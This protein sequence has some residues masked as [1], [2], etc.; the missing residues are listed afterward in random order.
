M[1]VM[2]VLVG[3]RPQLSAQSVTS[4]DI[5][6]AV[7]DPSGAVLPNIE[8]TLKNETKG[9][10]S[11]IYK[12]SRCLPLLAAGSWELHTLGLCSR[13]PGSNDEWHSNDRAGYHSQLSSIYR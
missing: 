10:A 7:G 12:F 1:L 8:V 9:Y 4:G 3:G 5:K 6:G 11:S 2:T 13:V